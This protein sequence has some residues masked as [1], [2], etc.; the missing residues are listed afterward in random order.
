MLPW[1]LED[2]NPGWAMWSQF[3]KIVGCQ[4]RN[5]LHSAGHT[6]FL[7]TFKEGVT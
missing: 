4:L 6:Q 3:M 7:K 2:E 5:S 1:K